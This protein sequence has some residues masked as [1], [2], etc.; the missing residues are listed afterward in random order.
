MISALPPLAFTL[1]A[2]N[3]ETMPLR[4]L[5]KPHRTEVSLPGPR[6]ELGSFLRSLFPKSSA[7]VLR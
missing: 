3:L 7:G 6:P 1:G 5:G 2:S 4:G